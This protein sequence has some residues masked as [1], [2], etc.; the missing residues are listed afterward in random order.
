[1]N[2][3]LNYFV[4]A[5]L[6][7]CLMLLMYVLFLRNE[8]DFAVKRIFLLVSI[9]AS[10]LFPLIQIDGLRS[11]YLPSLMQVVPVTWLPEVTVVAY[12]PV[13]NAVKINTWSIV[14]TIYAI[15]LVSAL[16]LFLIRLFMVARTLW[17]LRYYRVDNDLVFESEDN[18]S[19]FS[20]FRCIYIGQASQLSLDE[21]AMIIHHEQIHARRL[22]S[23]DI[24]LI[25]IVGVFFWFNPVV[26]LYKKIFIQLHE[27]EA[28]ARSV[29]TRDVNNY[30]SLLAKV[31][32]LSA[33]IKLANH[34]SN[35]LTVKRI[36]MMRTIKAK[37]KRWKYVAF[38]AVLPSFFFFVA[39]QEQ[40]ATELTEVAKNANNA[41]L[42]PAHVQARYD[43]L[44]KANPE[45]KILLLDLNQEAV[46]TLQ[47]LEKQYG[48][49]KSLEI[50]KPG[51]D[52]QKLNH[53]YTMV[54][55]AT[56]VQNRPEGAAPVN[57][58]E[59]T[60]A[61]V[62]YNETMSGIIEG[63]KSADAVYP[64]VDEAAQ[65]P[66]GLPELVKFLQTNL[67]YPK[68]ARDQG[69]E[70][71]VY[72]TFVVEKDGSISSAEVV[73]GVSLET[74]VEATRVVEMFPNW[75][76]GKHNGEVVRSSFVVPIKFKLASENPE[77]GQ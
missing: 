29:S 74:D 54:V 2:T 7:L 57:D 43:E 28:D 69:I 72:I 39:C 55:T 9:G 12:E 36:E 16:I 19:S 17:P 51:G 47:G 27:F 77:T 37:I 71:T 34:F 59:H 11:S 42:V 65:F 64:I 31:A 49:P 8:N 58:D 53:A 5:N 33:D 23:F 24:L 45:S 14:N 76:P 30:C 68:I 41:I 62:Q 38:A 10:L 4:E 40:V 75:I 70:G 3:F 15:G 44:R 63:A 22:H 20:F 6:G 32:L 67:K 21:K 18:K 61:I 1:M 52:G 56:S 66:G 73:K 48:S 60:Y 50:F 26:H 13:Q 46:S 25:N 35:S